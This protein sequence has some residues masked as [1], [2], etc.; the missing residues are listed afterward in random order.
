LDEKLTYSDFLLLQAKFAFWHIFVLLELSIEKILQH[1]KMS[2]FRIPASHP[3]QRHHANDLEEVDLGQ[4]RRPDSRH[5][6]AI[7]PLPAN[8]IDLES[9]R[10]VR[11]GSPGKFH[12]LAK[13]VVDSIKAR[14]IFATL[15]VIFILMLLWVVPYMM[16]RSRKS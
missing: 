2:S 5:L 12:Q 7:V 8:V 16:F 9:Q 10:S 13:I 11:K 14:R 15:G 4:V 1:L 3:F 6:N